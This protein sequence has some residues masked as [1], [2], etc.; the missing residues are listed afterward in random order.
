[1]E[2][3][4]AESDNLWYEARYNL[5]LIYAADGN[6]KAACGKLAQTRSEQPS[7]GSPQMKQRWDELQRK[8]C[9]QKGVIG[10]IR[11]P[12]NATAARLA[13]MTRRK[14]RYRPGWQSGR[15]REQFV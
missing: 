9:L 3:E 6:V 2:S 5:S 14:I 10:L 12:V 8:L 15:K 11:T 1:V 13:T 4:A 7:L